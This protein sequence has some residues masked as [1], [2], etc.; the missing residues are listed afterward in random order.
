MLG[1]RGAGEPLEARSSSAEQGTSAALNRV[2][3]VVVPAA[4]LCSVL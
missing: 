4:C 2:G 1:M 3:Q